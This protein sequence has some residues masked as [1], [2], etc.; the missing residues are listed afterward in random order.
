MPQEQ[1]AKHECIPERFLESTGYATSPASYRVPTKTQQPPGLRAEQ[2][3]MRSR[4]L[5]LG[6]IENLF[7]SFVS[8]LVLR[9]AVGI[10]AEK[11][12]EPSQTQAQFRGI[13]SPPH[14]VEHQV[15]PVTY[16]RGGAVGWNRE[17]GNSY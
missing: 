11:P 6:R 2:T 9:G 4:S 7:A 16:R 10:G 8:S 15:L 14:A 12:I 3:Q 17:P 13:T 5:V 1:E